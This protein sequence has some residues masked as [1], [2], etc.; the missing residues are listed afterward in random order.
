M[1]LRKEP[2]L[3]HHHCAR[4]RQA[5]EHSRLGLCSGG[6]GQEDCRG[7][8][9]VWRGGEEMCVREE[10]TISNSDVLLS[11]FTCSRGLRGSASMNLPNGCWLFRQHKAGLRRAHWQWIAKRFT[12]RHS[13]VVGHD[14]TVLEACNSCIYRVC[15]VCVIT[16]TPCRLARHYR[17]LGS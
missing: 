7:E 5:H 6:W 15:H 2:V 11:R 13:T 14:T 8:T 12:A 1:F 17:S 9:K 10:S 16:V 3:V 4:E